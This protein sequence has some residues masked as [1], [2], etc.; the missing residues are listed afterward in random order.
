MKLD[1]I[2][3]HY[4]EPWST[5]WYLFNS[6]AMQ[7]SVPWADVEVVIVNDGDDPTLDDVD[8]TAYP[9]KVKY[10][11]KPHGGVSAARNY[12]FD[13]SDAEYVM[14]CDI[15][16]GFLSNYGLHMLL[17]AAD[18]GFDYLV[19]AFA[20]ES[21]SDD[22]KTLALVGHQF[23][24]TFMHGK[25]Y[26]REFLK[27]FDLRFNTAMTVHEDG[28]FNALVYS[29]ATVE[30]AKIKKI[31]APFYLWCW[32]WNSTVRRDREDFV[33]KTYE[34]LMQTRIGLCREL[35]KRG[36]QEEFRVAVT[37]TVL[38]SYYDFQKSSFWT[39]KNDS[40]RKKAEKAFQKFWSEFKSVF[41]DITNQQIA[42][43]AQVSRD[44]ARKNG[45]LMER[46]DLKAFLK[47]IDK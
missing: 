5:C 22:N 19:G 35:K 23:D 36:Y 10:M 17:A 46:E 18:E 27:K 37:M 43:I 26:R 11:K 29:T 4:K 1:I 42:D 38:N 41:Y 34:N 16:D 39:A 30:K 9:F 33:L 24:L 28:Y 40:Y 44:N 45:L 3:P 2:I 47:R 12:G 14:W 15:D 6:I 20:E 25:V 7:R 8:W 21:L 13:N 31:D 32:N